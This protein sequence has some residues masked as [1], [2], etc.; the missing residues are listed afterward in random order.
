DGRRRETTI[1]VPYYQSHHNLDPGRTGLLVEV[2]DRVNGVIDYEHILV[3]VA[4]DGTRINEW[5]LGDIIARHMAANGDDPS[6]FVRL[7]I[8]WFHM[9]SSAYD[10]RDDS[11]I[12]SSRENFVIKVDYQTQEIL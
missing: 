2:D 8:D 10:P 3:E 9:N 11:I 7:G 12:L 6:R 4:P 1:A 5:K